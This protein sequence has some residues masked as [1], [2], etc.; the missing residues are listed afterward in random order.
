MTERPRMA[1]IL[2]SVI[3]YPF[4]LAGSFLLLQF[5]QAHGAVLGKDL[6]HLDPL[7]LLLF[8]LG[9]LAACGAAWLLVQP[10]RITWYSGLWW[11][12][13]LLGLGF[14]TK[15]FTL[16]A[17][18]VVVSLPFYLFVIAFT[19]EFIFRGCLEEGLTPLGP[20]TAPLLIGLLFGLSHLPLSLMHGMALP[21][22]VAGNLL[23][24]PVAHLLFRWLRDRGG[25]ALSIVV[26]GLL[27]FL[28]V[29]S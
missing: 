24:G 16:P 7:G 28:G 6:D 13:P 25:L 2:G 15:I 20:R 27:H 14:L 29:G 12:Y 4:F 1:Q 17:A 21:L 11:P 5:Q 10:A 22:A 18:Q 19:G 9:A 3:F 8:L 23:I 26:H